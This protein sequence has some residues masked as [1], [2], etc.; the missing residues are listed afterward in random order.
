M[1]TVL[2]LLVQLCIDFIFVVGFILIWIKFKKPQ[3][4]DPRLSAGLQVLQNKIAVLEDL[5]DRTETQVQQL[6]TLLEKKLLDVQ[7]KM[8]QAEV[9]LS[10][11]TQSME[12]SLEVAKIFQ[13]KIPHDEIIERQNTV[14]FVRAALLANQGKSAHEIAEEVELPIGEIDFIVK[15]NKDELS[16]DEEQLPEWVLS[17]LKTSHVFMEKEIQF[18]ENPSLKTQ[19]PTFFKSPA[20][21]SNSDQEVLQQLGEKFRQAQFI[22]NNHNS[23]TK[24]NETNEFEKNSKEISRAQTTDEPI[25]QTSIAE[26][27]LAESLKQESRFKNINTNA[28]NNGNGKENEFTILNANNNNSITNASINFDTPSHI[29]EINK[30]RE[31]LSL[32]DKNIELKKA[33]SVT[34]QNIN[35]ANKNKENKTSGNKILESNVLEKLKL[36]ANRI[37]ANPNF[38]KISNVIKDTPNSSL[39]QRAKVLG[40]RPVVFPRLEKNEADKR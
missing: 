23:I 15:V 31:I 19:I 38:E 37:K 24:I 9:V 1:T 32:D 26:E 36:E 10:K 12:K 5:G 11:I 35:S 27:L 29:N 4:E 16:F 30:N 22:V 25:L 8:D 2:S 21:V 20:G 18:M 7:K 33:N 40:I 3:S 14:K 13:D 39:S 6:T 28:N 34:Y 17:E